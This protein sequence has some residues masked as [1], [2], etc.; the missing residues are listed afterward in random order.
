MSL[1]KNTKLTPAR[2]IF[3]VILLLIGVI[4]WLHDQSMKRPQVIR[5]DQTTTHPVYWGYVD[6]TNRI[7]SASDEYIFFV[8]Y[9]D[10]RILYTTGI[11]K[12][13]CET[14]VN[15]VVHLFA[16]Q[17]NVYFLTDRSTIGC[18]NATEEK[19]VFEDSFQPKKIRSSV[20]GSLE[21]RLVGA[22][23]TGVY[24]L[25]SNLS[26]TV[27]CND[28]VVIYRYAYESQKLEPILQFMS[29]KKC[30]Y[31]MIDNHTVYYDLTDIY[32]NESGF[33]S[34]NIDTQQ[35][36]RLSSRYS[37][38]HNTMHIRYYRWEDYIL[39]VSADSKDVVGSDGHR[40]LEYMTLA[41]TDGSE[42]IVYPIILSDN[43]NNYTLAGDNFYYY[44]TSDDSWQC[45]NL[46]T[47]TYS[48]FSST[49]GFGNVFSFQNDLA[50]IRREGHTRLDA[51][52]P[53]IYI[54]Q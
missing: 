21:N 14:P 53:T 51:S 13:I 2:L 24:I 39:F 37:I 46:R 41:K 30:F 50:L 52:V 26:G 43:D 49:L 23:E 20:I 38:A 8:S 7:V 48:L 9:A 11:G 16:F 4:F 36:C 1:L 18:Y 15:G 6:D 32:G 29:A 27:P 40:P 28:D 33:Y 25:S 45:Y 34:Y 47:Q 19:V 3:I 44:D 35:T 22:D 42:E 31:A 17:D 54:F 12:K 5:G 10:K